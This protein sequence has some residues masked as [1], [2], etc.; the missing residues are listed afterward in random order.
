MAAEGRDKSRVLVLDAFG[1]VGTREGGVYIRI[2]SRCK[3]SYASAAAA[4]GTAT[5][6]AGTG[7][8]VRGVGY[9]A[10]R[11]LLDPRTIVPGSGKNMQYQSYIRHATNAFHDNDAGV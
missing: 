6:P 1:C 2:G 4:A 11:R 8:C 9:A 5:R 3:D 7:L 10:M